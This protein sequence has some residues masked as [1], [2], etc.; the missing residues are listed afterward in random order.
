MIVL[1]GVIAAIVMLAFAISRRNPSGDAPS[2]AAPDRDSIAGAILV[3]LARLG[4]AERDRAADIVR[5]EAGLLGLQP[6]DID[7]ASWAAAY[8]RAGTIEQREWLL[9]AA[10]RTSIRTSLDFPLEQYTA[11]VDLSF[12][13]GFQT[14]ALARLRSRYNFSFEDYARRNRPRSADRAATS[15]PLFER[16]T[17][18][19]SEMLAALELRGEVNRHQVISAYRRLAAKHHPDRFHDATPDEQREAAVR[20]MRITEAYERLLLRFPEP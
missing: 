7:I 3:Q 15:A 19:Q 9:D 8:A 1:G 17:V 16:K 11:L 12:A 20:F 10:V 18:D 5:E 6:K 14:D 2:K 13:L 4:G